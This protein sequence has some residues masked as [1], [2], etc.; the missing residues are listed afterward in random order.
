M[1]VKYRYRE[2]D[3]YDLGNFG[4]WVKH[5]YLLGKMIITFTP[6]IWENGHGDT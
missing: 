1:G 3:S 5:R 4:K 2:K 6:L